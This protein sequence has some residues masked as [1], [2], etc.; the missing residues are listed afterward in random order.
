MKIGDFDIELRNYKMIA[1]HDDTLPYQAI[2]YING[3]KAAVCM[4]DGWGGETVVTIVNEKLFKEAEQAVV[5]T[6]W[7]EDYK[8][9]MV[10]L[11]DVLA[12]GLEKERQLNKFITS[13]QRKNLVLRKEGKTYTVSLSMTIAQILANEST[14]VQLMCSIEK[15]KADGYE[16]LNKNIPFLFG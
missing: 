13:N 6:I 5:Q 7:F 3:K 4:N 12:Y 14:K 16:I 10:S 1:G 2:M 11:A 9:T 8:Y 15:R